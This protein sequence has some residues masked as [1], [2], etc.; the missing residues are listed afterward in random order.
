[1]ALMQI[2]MKGPAERST[3]FKV[4]ETIQVNIV[5]VLYPCSEK[6]LAVLAFYTVFS[7]SFF[8]SQKDVFPSQYGAKFNAALKKLMWL[9]LSRLENALPKPSM[10]EV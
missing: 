7:F 1:M 4:R 3:F 9:F 10:E 5:G 2:L 6:K 8:L